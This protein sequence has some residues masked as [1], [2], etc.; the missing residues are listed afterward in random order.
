MTPDTLQYLAE[1]PDV[2]VAVE[3]LYRLVINLGISVSD[4]VPILFG[5]EALSWGADGAKIVKTFLAWFKVNVPIDPTP[6]VAVGW[7]L[8]PEIPDALLAGILPTHLVE[9]FLQGKADLPRV[10]LGWRK[11]RDALR[12]PGV[13]PAAL[14]AFS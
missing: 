6:D 13:S 1:D 11:I 3:A 8:I 7:A 14:D 12:S 10:I 9:T 4:V 2:A 5:G